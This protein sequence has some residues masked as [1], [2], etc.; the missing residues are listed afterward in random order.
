MKILVL[1]PSMQDTEGERIAPLIIF[2]ATE[3][4]SIDHNDIH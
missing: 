1:K 4:H 2:I 3:P